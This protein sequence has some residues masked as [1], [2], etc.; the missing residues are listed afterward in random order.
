MTVAKVWD[1]TTS[2]W[3]PV[4]GPVSRADFNALAWGTPVWTDLPAL[5]NGFTHYDQG[6]Y[7]IDPWGYVRMRGELR[8]PASATG[9][10]VL[11]FTMPAGYRPPKR[12]Y[13]ILFENTTTYRTGYISTDGTV[14]LSFGLAANSVTNIGLVTYPT[15]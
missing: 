1:Q 4:T 9:A 11:L 10:D 3:I 12:C 7:T 5:Q 2:S 6:Q 8:S 13:C 15:R 14:R